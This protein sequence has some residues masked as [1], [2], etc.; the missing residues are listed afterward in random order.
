MIKIV[1]YVLCIMIDAPNKAKKK[2]IWPIQTWWVSPKIKIKTFISCAYKSIISQINSDG[3]YNEKIRKTWQEIIWSKTWGSEL[4]T[5]IRKTRVFENTKSSL[6]EINFKKILSHL[7]ILYVDRKK[8][9]FST[10]KTNKH[11]ENY[12]S[13][14]FFT[15]KIIVIGRECFFFF[16]NTSW[17]IYLYIVRPIFTS[18]CTFL[19]FLMFLLEQVKKKKSSKICK[20]R[21]I[22]LTWNIKKFVKSHW[23]LSNNL[24]KIG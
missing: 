15:H 17:I 21:C 9:F 10:L 13:S 6:Q 14:T 12:F 3:K 8:H 1:L 7:S 22:R 24:T 20:T 4:G 5:K 11:I 19:K 18:F 23:K 16:R 2:K